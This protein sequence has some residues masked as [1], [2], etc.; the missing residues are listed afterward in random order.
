[1]KK[2]NTGILKL[3]SH[4]LSGFLLLLGMSTF[5]ACVKEPPVAE[6]GAPW[7]RFKVNGN[8]KSDST[9]ANIPHIMVIT[10]QDTTL[11]DTS[12]NYLIQIDGYPSDQSFAIRF[13][14]AD[15]NQNGAF[16]NKDTVTQFSDVH[17]TN[18]DGNW[19][20]GETSKVLNVKM[21]PQ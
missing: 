4:I 18:G 14:D 19:Y 1:M 15:G 17:F 16:Q 7:A 11:S 20:S 5:T 2:L 8:I 6:Y 21:K 9:Q 10:S 12:G 3:Y 13:V